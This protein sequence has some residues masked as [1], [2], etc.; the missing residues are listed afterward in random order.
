MGTLEGKVA[1]VTG[2]S[3]A[4]TMAVTPALLDAGATVVVTYRRESDL[5][6]LREHAGIAPDAKLSGITLDLTDQEAV[7]RAYADIAVLLDGHLG[8]GHAI[9]VGIDGSKGEFQFLT[10]ILIQIHS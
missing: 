7:A 9:G 5:A 2:A 8:G 1:I 10:I 3:A 4:L 6:K